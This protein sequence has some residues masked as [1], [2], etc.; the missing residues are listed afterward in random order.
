MNK[1][2]NLYWSKSADNYSNIIDNEFNSFR[3]ERWEKKILK[4]APSVSDSERLKV[5]DCGCGPGFFS[6]LL[7]RA[8]CDVTGIDGSEEMLQKAR[9]KA[10]HFGVAPHFQIMDCQETEFADDTF[11]LIV[12]RNVTHALVYHR[13][14][15][16]E[17]LRILKPGG[18]LLIFDA[19]WHLTRIPGPLQDEARRRHEECMRIYGDD[20]TT[21]RKDDKKEHSGDDS[22]SRELHVLGDRI[23]PDWD[24]GLL[25]GIGFTRITTERSIVDEMWDDKEK[26]IYGC[27]PMFMIRAEKPGRNA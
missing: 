17:W 7:S 10:E 16:E 22:F 21:R 1:K 9:S 27:T 25:E 19:N 13:E 11:D 15:Y 8:G 12:S 20:F 24:M 6:I 3:P 5:L 14:A 4:N 23:R 18:V 26:L 2:M